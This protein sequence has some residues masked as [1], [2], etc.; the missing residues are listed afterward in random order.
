MNKCVVILDAYKMCKRN[1]RVISKSKKL[2]DGQVK[3]R[4]K[5]GENIIDLMQ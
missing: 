1:E 2:Y 4:E 5:W 3:S